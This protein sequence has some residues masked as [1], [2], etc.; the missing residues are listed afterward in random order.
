MIK[1]GL[2]IGN[3]KLSCII[4]DYK[5]SSDIKILSMSSVPTNNIKKNVILNHELLFDQL[6]SLLLENEK[7]SQTK[8]NSVNLNFSLLKSSSYY[9]DSEIKIENEK[10]SQLHLKKI[11]NQS[12]FFKLNTF[13]FELYNNIISYEVDNRQYFAPPLENY[14]DKIKIYFYKIITQKKYIENFSSIFKK[15]KINIENYI[16]SPLSASLSSLTKDERE[17]GTI[18]INLGHSTSSI[19][20]FEN[21]IFIYGDTIGIGSNN[22]TLDIARGVSTSIASAERLKTLYGSLTSS[23][24][25]EHEIIEIPIISG[26][27]NSFNQITRSNL[28]S[29]IKP[30]IEETLEILWQKI[31]DN[32]LSNKKIGNVVLTGGGSQLDEIENYVSTIFASGARVAKPLENFNIMKE[33]NNPSFCDV[34]GSIIYDPKKFNINF[35]KNNYKN[36][37]KPSFSGFFSWLDQYI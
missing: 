25:D 7:Q 15:L 20:V 34:I 3:S 11:I 28:N 14:S 6:K 13:D 2:D 21:N 17:L 1:A 24:S 30:R 8:L 16:P 4:A 27:N 12:D 29:I 19:S 36:G 35:L 33:H 10:I 5:N 9:Y 37:K 26:E 18:C 31:K 32:N 22:V 23:P